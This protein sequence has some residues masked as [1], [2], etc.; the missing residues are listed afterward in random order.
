MFASASGRIGPASALHA[1]TR[2][3]PRPVPEGELTGGGVVSAWAP[4]TCPPPSIL[5]FPHKGGRDFT[6]PCQRRERG[7]RW[8]GRCCRVKIRSAQDM[9]WYIMVYNGKQ[10]Y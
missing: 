6:S 4:S 2:P 1:S 3:S 9:F 8:D 10:A 5:S 7:N